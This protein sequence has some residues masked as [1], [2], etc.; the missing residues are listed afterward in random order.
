MRPGYAFVTSRTPEASEHLHESRLGGRG[1]RIECM[2]VELV[3][4][5]PEDKVTLAWSAPLPRVVVG[6]KAG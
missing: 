4:H 2:L 3:V 6:A 1:R 5:S